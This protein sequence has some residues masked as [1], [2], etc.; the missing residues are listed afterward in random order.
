PVDQARS[1]KLHKDLDDSARKPL[2]QGEAF[3]R[4]V[5]GGAEPLQLIDDDPAR[6]RLPG[7]DPFKESGT[8]E[9]APVR[10]LALHEL[11]LDHHLGA[12]ASMISARLPQHVLAAHALEPAQHILQRVVERMPNV[13]GTGGIGW[14]DDHAKSFRR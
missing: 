4:P 3:A 5:A 9:H 2:V 10:L 12:D 1:I 11:T 6:F 8:A 7:P 14:R 13:Q